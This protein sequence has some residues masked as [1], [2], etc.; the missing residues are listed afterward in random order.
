MP[1]GDRCAFR[2]VALAA[3]IALGGCDRDSRGPRYRGAGN[4]TP[5]SGGTLTCS[6]SVAVPTLDPAIAY[7]EVGVMVVANLYETLLDYDAA[8]PGDPTSGTRLVP[9]LA[10]RWTV[11]AD[12]RSYRFELRAGA[13]YA[14]GRAIVAGD[15]AYALR[16]VLKMPD[17]PYGRL[18][19]GITGA[20]AFA[21]G[22]RD[23][24]PGLEIADERT[25]VV[26]LDAADAAFAYAMAMPFSAPLREDFVVASGGDLRR[27]VLASGPLRLDRWDEGQRLVLARNPHYWDPARPFLDGVTVLENLPENT[28]FLLFEAGRLDLLDHVAAPDWIWL[29]EQVA[30]RPF[31]DTRAQMSVFGSRMNVTV[32]PFDDARVR[33]ALNL[34]VNRDHIVKLLA[35]RAVP[36][37]GMLPPGL[38]GR[39]ELSPYPHDPAGARVLLAEAGY[40]DGFAVDYVTVPNDDANKL[41][42]SLQADL[43]A[44][45]VRMSIR[46][47]SWPAFLDTVGR[48]DGAPF[49]MTSWIMDYP[50]AASFFDPRFHS[51]AIGDA[52][53]SNDSFYAVPEVDRLLDDARGAPD[54]AAAVAL[55]Q[56]VDRR[57]HDDAPWIWGYHAVMTEAMQPYVKGFA[58]HPVWVRDFRDVWLDLDGRGR[59]VPR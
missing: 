4:A 14:D 57:L 9:G 28:A 35:G 18:L 21:A 13:R 51:R 16:R 24:V 12:G 19:S 41:A 46:V 33:R 11:S 44:V 50:H 1:M 54:P 34:A 26:H 47:L 39:A 52:S 23:D 22:E 27:T 59:R 58:P 37:H 15:L 29:S 3:A 25:F 42:Q 30:W 8:V 49:S 2:V 45:G 38:A 17:S 7:D 53:S 31:L 43:A 36:A 48:K 10:D 6:T 40:P 5:R 20:G 56:Q 55:Y 32:P